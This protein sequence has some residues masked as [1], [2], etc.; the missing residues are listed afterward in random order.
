MQFPV[1]LGTVTQ[2]MKYNNMSKIDKWFLYQIGVID[3]FRKLKVDEQN[4]SAEF[5]LDAKKLGFSD[6]Q[7]GLLAGLMKTRSE[8]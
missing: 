3:S 7:I 8:D 4:I 6:K 5:L 2:L 1:R